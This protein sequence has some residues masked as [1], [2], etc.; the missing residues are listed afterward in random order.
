MRLYGLLAFMGQPKGQVC[1]GWVVATIHFVTPIPAHPKSIK[2]AQVCKP[3]VG[4]CSG[5]FI[6]RLVYQLSVPG[7]FK[8]G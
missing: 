3:R 8:K 4:F 6:I 1:G 2:S 7:I 5:I